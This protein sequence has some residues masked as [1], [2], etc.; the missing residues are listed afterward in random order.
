MD[1]ENV[2]VA[3][4]PKVE[5]EVGATETVGEPTPEKVECEN[6]DGEKFCSVCSSKE[7]V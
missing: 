6:C 4:E 5:G 2:E 3:G 1:E 7:V